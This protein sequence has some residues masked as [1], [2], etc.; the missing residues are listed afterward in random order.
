MLM[1]GMK[2]ALLRNNN[3]YNKIK[4]YCFSSSKKGM[5]IRN[6][7][8]NYSNKFNVL[9]NEIIKENNN[10]ELN[11]KNK[12]II[13]NFSK[14]HNNNNNNNNNERRYNNNNVFM[15]KIMNND[16]IMKGNNNFVVIKNRYG[17]DGY[18]KEITYKGFDEEK[19][20]TFFNKDFHINDGWKIKIERARELIDEANKLMDKEEFQF[21]E[22][23]L[24]TVIGTYES[25]S[26]LKHKY[27]LLQITPDTY[28]DVPENQLIN[29]D[30]SEFDKIDLRS[31]NYIE[32]KIKKE[33][34]EML[35]QPTLS[36]GFCYHSLG[37]KDL[38]KTN[39]ENSIEWLINSRGEDSFV[40][41]AL[42]NYGDLLVTTGEIEEGISICKQAIPLIENAFT[43][44]HE[45]TAAAYSNLSQALAAQG[46]KDEALPHAKE[47]LDIFVKQLGKY[48]PYTMGSVRN[49]RTLLKDL[50]MDEEFKQLNEEWKDL[51]SQFELIDDI[52]QPTPERIEEIKK[53]FESQ[54]S[55]KSV[56]PEGMIFNKELM[57]EHMDS[58]V[59]TW[60]SKDLPP[61][62]DDFIEGK[63]KKAN[64]QLSSLENKAKSIPEI[65]HSFLIKNEFHGKDLSQE[66]LYNE[67]LKFKAL[68]PEEYRKF[69]DT[70][71][72]NLDKERFGFLNDPQ[73]E[74]ITDDNYD[75]HDL[76]N[77]NDK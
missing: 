22:E 32:D 44:D 42:L 33:K 73:F 26:D 30:F 13:Y 65:D 59:K 55:C 67:F 52:E 51:E 29:S 66:E 36:L 35:A 20:D 77:D 53:Q 12:K 60:N 2:R 71:Y 10:N 17:I 76:M 58:F 49:Y 74:S 28:H 45:V 19:L 8:G 15:N 31:K 43:K 61:L 56:D 64:Q 62:P 21:A 50:K 37:N 3:S 46:K 75:P 11:N 5:I 39:Y 48:N 14:I 9:I 7:N 24:V 47:A 72:Q 1:N 68:G 18:N 34:E 41:Q 27:I 63:K 16:I 38:A 40:G 69:V 25:Y 54:S 70:Y 23:K 57:N 6:N 4:G